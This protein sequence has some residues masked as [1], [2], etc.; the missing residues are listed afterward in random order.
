MKKQLRI[1]IVVTVLIVMGVA[2][3]Y[4]LSN[5]DTGK[6]PDNTPEE[7]RDLVVVVA[8]D[9]DNDYPV[10]PREVVQLY[11]RILKCYFNEEHDD[12]EL[13]QLACQARKLL[14]DELLA[15][16]DFSDS[17]DMLCNEIDEYKT[18]NTKIGSIFLD[19]S[20]QV[21]Y[22]TLDGQSTAWLNCIYYLKSD[23]GTTK[24]TETYILRKDDEG[25]WKILGWQ[26]T[27]PDTDNE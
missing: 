16:N 7:T 21:Q 19:K 2:F 24:A 8:K 14:D 5:R 17:Y 18:K 4:Y 15:N 1:M 27:R 22:S 26:V 9:L 11:N 10:S 23:D 6:T 12:K 13:V 20:S 25:K 3:Y